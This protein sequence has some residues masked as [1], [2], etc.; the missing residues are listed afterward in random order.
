MSSVARSVAHMQL[1][2]GAFFQTKSN[3]FLTPEPD[4]QHL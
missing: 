4:P 2:I 1:G 3:P